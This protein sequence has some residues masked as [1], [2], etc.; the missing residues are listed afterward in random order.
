VT[1]PI[2]GH[3]DLDRLAELDEGLLPD[4]EAGAAQAHLRDCLACRE[5]LAAIR[6]TRAVL[7]TL[8]AEP[9][10]AAVAARLDETL[11]GVTGSTTVVPMLS[12]RP[13]RWFNRPSGAGLAAAAVVA[14][15][16]GAVV[17][18][19]SVKD[20]DGGA[21]F[22]A[23]DSSGA[24]PEAAPAYPVLASGVTY[25]EANA[26]SR[27]TALEQA[28]DT[29]VTMDSDAKTGAQSSVPLREAEPGDVPAE[30]RAM[31]VSSEELLSCVAKLTA[32][33]PQVLPVAV[34]FVRWTDPVHKL[35]DVPAVAIVLPGQ[36][37][38]NDGV[39]VVGPDCATALDQDIYLFAG[40]S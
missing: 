35:H 32:G 24:A 13:S 40:V 38:D 17:V 15:L 25:T 39:Y 22:G 8:P 18:G 3:F 33:G 23:L 9:M 14:A 19:A 31:F 26:Q 6:A 27:V 7:G 12:P 16:V 34:D 10:P 37:G 28:A 4:T 5:Q 1:E 20:D 29:V 30:T 11:A 21:D 2:S 36:V